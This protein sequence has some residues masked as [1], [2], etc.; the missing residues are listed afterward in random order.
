[1]KRQGRAMNR[2][3]GTAQRVEKRAG[4]VGTVEMTDYLDS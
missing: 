2:K 4:G 1:M 3:Y